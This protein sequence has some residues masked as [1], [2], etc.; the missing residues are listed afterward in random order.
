ME[1]SMSSKALVPR[2]QE[3]VCRTFPLPKWM[4]RKNR[5]KKIWNSGRPLLKPHKIDK[6]HNKKIKNDKKGSF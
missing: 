4:I 2:L 3:I 6:I 5:K 1:L